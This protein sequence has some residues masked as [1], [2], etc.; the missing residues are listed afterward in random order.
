MLKILIAATIAM[1]L[2]ACGG[3][4]PEPADDGRVPPPG[5]VNCEVRPEV[6]K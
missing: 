1:L 4:D 2:T 3:G 5:P 6:C